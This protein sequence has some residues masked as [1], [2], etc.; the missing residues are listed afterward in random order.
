MAAWQNLPTVAPVCCALDMILEEASE[1]KVSRARE[2][3]KEVD[4]LEMDTYPL[5]AM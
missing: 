3:W 1:I 5:E 2:I 4:A